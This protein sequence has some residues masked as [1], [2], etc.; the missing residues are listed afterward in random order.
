MITPQLKLYQEWV[1]C[2]KP[3]RISFGSRGGKTRFMREEYALYNI[4]R[5]EGK[6]ELDFKTD[7]EAAAFFERAKKL[8]ELKI[9]PRDA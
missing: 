2:G 9:P 3:K 5:G 4:M 7:A 6:I 1:R 8:A